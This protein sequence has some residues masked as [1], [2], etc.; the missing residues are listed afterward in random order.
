MVRPP[1]TID[2]SE[3]SVKTPDQGSSG[4]KPARREFEYRRVDHYDPDEY[5]WI[6]FMRALV[7]LGI[8]GIFGV[9]IYM[10]V[11]GSLG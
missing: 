10:I 2:G 3:V 7:F 9:I 6:L 4:K 1:K 8:V 11:V 5:A